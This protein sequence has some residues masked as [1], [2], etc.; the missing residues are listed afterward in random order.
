MSDHVTRVNLS[1]GDLFTFPTQTILAEARSLIAKGWTQSVLSRNPDGKECEPAGD[2]PCS[3]CLTGA[4]ACAINRRVHAKLVEM[5]KAPW[6]EEVLTWRANKEY[7]LGA[8]TSVR[9]LIEKANRMDSLAFLWN[10]H[11]ERTQEEVIAALDQTIYHIQ[12][13]G[14]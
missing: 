3:W 11:K 13:D 2:E 7:V 8:E 10:D 1:Q 12:G 9:L 4:V 14:S 5:D 6:V